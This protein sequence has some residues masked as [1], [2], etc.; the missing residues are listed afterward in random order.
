LFH[1]LQTKKTFGEDKSPKPRPKSNFPGGG[2]IGILPPPPGGVRIAAP[3][4]KHR[5]PSPN[6]PHPAP[7]KPAPPVNSTAGNET[8]LFFGKSGSFSGNDFAPMRFVIL[9]S[10]EYKNSGMENSG[11]FVKQRNLLFGTV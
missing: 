11:I 8:D 6:R 10:V 1:L 9:I 5:A 7:A 3:P 2:G 4:S